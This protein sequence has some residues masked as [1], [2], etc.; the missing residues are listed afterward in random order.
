LARMGTLRATLVMV[1]RLAQR[2]AGDRDMQ[3]IAAGE[4]WKALREGGRTGFGEWLYAF[5]DEMSE[6]VSLDYQAWVRRFDTP[7]AYDLRHMQ[8]AIAA[9]RRR[10]LVSIVMPVYNTP[11]QWLRLCV[12]SVV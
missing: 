10:P 11:E 4:A 6:G 5:H 8:A 7:A 12:D 3:R 2:L 1:H 9:F